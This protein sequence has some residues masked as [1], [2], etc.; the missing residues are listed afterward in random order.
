MGSSYPTLQKPLLLCGIFFLSINVESESVYLVRPLSN[1]HFTTDNKIP[2]NRLIYVIMY[3]LV[4]T[5]QTFRHTYGFQVRLHQQETKNSFNS[6]F[7]TQVF[8]ILL[9]GIPNAF[10]ILFLFFK[11][12][13]LI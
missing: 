9:Q 1:P 2:I 5:D 3:L 13:I 7:T 8:K 12:P 4:D 11:L 6:I 10:V